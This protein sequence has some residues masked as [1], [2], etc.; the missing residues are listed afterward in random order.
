MYS[1]HPY[2]K[3]ETSNLFMYTYQEFSVEEFHFNNVCAPICV[4]IFNLCIKKVEMQEIWEKVIIS[5]NS[6]YAW[7][8]WK[9]YSI[10][11][12]E[13]DLANK[14][15]R[16]WNVWRRSSFYWT[17]QNIRSVWSNKET[18]TLSKLHEIQYFHYIF[19]MV[20]RHLRFDW[21]SSNYVISLQPLRVQWVF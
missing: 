7:L 20:S 4:Y 3:T 2:Y 5:Q 17:D 12:T 1:M 19:Y 8:R 18:V 16:T 9:S 10:S 14:L 15:W 6:F 13:T 21:H 11:T